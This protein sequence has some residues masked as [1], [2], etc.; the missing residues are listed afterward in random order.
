MSDLSVLWLPWLAGVLVLL[1]H[2]PLGQQV[3]RR[4]IVFIDLAIAQVAAF[5][6]LVGSSL[7]DGAW[8]S[9]LAGSAAAL[10]GAGVVA[11]LST[12]WPARREALIGL[13][14]VAAA[15]LAMLWVSA[16]P[17][18]HQKLTT[19]L[20]GDVLWVHGAALLPLAV[21]TV[22]VLALLA[23]RPAV[24]ARSAVFYPCFAVLVSLSVPLLG[25]YLV[26]ATLIV[27]ALALGASRW[28]ARGAVLLGA[29]G[30]AV[31]LLVSLVWDL[32][33][34]PTVVLG[35]MASSVLA[36]CAPGG[37]LRR[38]A[39]NPAEVAEHGKP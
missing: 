32:P 26:F 9:G 37:A 25:L 21:A 35:L 8:A 29:A 24:L 36:A 13:V 3:L 10:L 33:S 18:G 6:V 34:G 38:P 12:R 14:Y 5:G 1:T 22:P 20:S 23:A 30:Y 11:W 27:P 16:D 17:R 4:G 31:G 7:V 15:A 2:V 39:A 28:G 19:M